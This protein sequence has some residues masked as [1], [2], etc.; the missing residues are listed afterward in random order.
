MVDKY[1]INIKV[2]ATFC[3]I[4]VAIQIF[5]NVKMDVSIIMRSGGRKGSNYDDLYIMKVYLG[6]NDN[7]NE[8]K[9][10]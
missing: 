3:F 7:D 8:K 10:K 2:F 5:Y 4:L 6:T 9:K 1:K